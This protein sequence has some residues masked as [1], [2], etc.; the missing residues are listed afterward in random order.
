VRSNG[1]IENCGREEGHVFL[2]IHSFEP[3]DLVAGK[4]PRFN[5]NFRP[6]RTAQ[7]G[8]QPVWR[9]RPDRR[10]A[11]GPAQSRIGPSHVKPPPGAGS[12]AVRRTSPVPEETGRMCRQ[13][14]P[15]GMFS[16]QWPPASQHDA[17]AAPGLRDAS[18]DPALAHLAIGRI[19]PYRPGVPRKRTAVLGRGVEPGRACGVIGLGTRVQL[20][21]TEKPAN[22][23]QDV[24]W[25][26]HRLPC[27]MLGRPRLALS[28]RWRARW[29]RIR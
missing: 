9:S 18:I 16:C 5:S 22:R 1:R 27:V 7:V 12:H 13:R 14:M 10:A 17:R 23:L 8:E 24:R 3:D 26:E 6:V 29:R 2:Q 4:A 19:A 25:R 15:S 28:N 20:N 21:A 11:L